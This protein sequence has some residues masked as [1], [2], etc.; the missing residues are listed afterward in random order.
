MTKYVLNSGGI[1]RFPELKKLFHQE[2]INE[3]NDTLRVLV[4]IFAEPREYW[5]DKYQRCWNSI[6]E[7]L[8]SGVTATFELALPNDFIAQ[9]ENAEV[10]YF[11]G[12]DDTLLQYWMR[13]FDLPELFKEKVVATASASSDM[14]SVSFWPYDWR[15]CMNGLGI[16]P[17]KFI[18]HYGAQVSGT[19][20][21]VDWEAAYQDLAAYGDKSLPVHALTEGNY[22]IVEQ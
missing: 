1:K 2:L 16:L 5:E 20:P 22:L 7:D 6:T 9:C 19:R 13:Q 15:C 12:G 17:I 21:P 10:I 18:P 11:L 3:L 14:L 4:C 8:P